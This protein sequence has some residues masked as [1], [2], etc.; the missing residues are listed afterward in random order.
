MASSL[1]KLAPYLPSHDIVKSMFPD[2]DN[3]N[4][5]LLIRKGIF[6]YE[7]IDCPDKLYE[8]ALPS[9]EK[10]YSSLYDSSVSDQDYEH[11]QHVWNAF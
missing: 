3:A 11:A 7:Y 10:F 9:K 2:I 1:E 5:Q 8:T 4:F 6:P